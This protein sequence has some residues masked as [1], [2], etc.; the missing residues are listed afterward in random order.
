MENNIIKITVKKEPE[1][2]TNHYFITTGK[3]GCVFPLKDDSGIE[4]ILSE[5]EKHLNILY[6]KR[7][8]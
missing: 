7:E 5:I 2:K 4:E 8:S 1:Q 3:G 6:G